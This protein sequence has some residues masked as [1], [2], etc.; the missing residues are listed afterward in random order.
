MIVNVNNITKDKLIFIN[1]INSISMVHIHND[2][3]ALILF[4]MIIN[5]NA[6]RT[7]NELDKTY[8]YHKYNIKSLIRFNIDLKIF[9]ELQEYIEKETSTSNTIIRFNHNSF[10]IKDYNPIY[11][12]ITTPNTV[13]IQ[14]QTKSFLGKS[15]NGLNV[16]WKVINYTAVRTASVVYD[17][18]SGTKE[19]PK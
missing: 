19:D 2:K 15:I 9:N 12:L 10:L 1:I 6:C 18:Y 4:N 7:G 14:N 5:I 8:L 3:I 11:T 17:Y 16:C 13:V